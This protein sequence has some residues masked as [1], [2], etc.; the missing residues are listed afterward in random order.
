MGPAAN[1]SVIWPAII[2]FLT[3]I[4]AILAMIYSYF[5]EVQVTETGFSKKGVFG[6]FS[7]KFDDIEEVFCDVGIISFKSDGKE[8]SLGSLYTN[9]DEISK[10][11]EIKIEGRTDINFTGKDK[12]ISKYFPWALEG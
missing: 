3:I 10:L 5:Y 4:G 9:F 2:L 1:N 7:L 6:S 11:V 8:I 12:R